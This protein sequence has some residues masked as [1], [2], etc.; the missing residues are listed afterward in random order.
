MDKIFDPYFT[1]KE[2]GEGAGLGLSVVQ[3]IVE[4]HGGII[5]LSSEAEKGTSF[6]VFLPVSEDLG[7]AE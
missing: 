6:H 2:K 4:D 5:Q 7:E 1:T 3:G